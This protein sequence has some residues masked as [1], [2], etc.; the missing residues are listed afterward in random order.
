MYYLT[1]GTLKYKIIRGVF[2]TLIFGSAVRFEANKSQP[3]AMTMCTADVVPAV[4]QRS[5]E[6]PPCVRKLQSD[7]F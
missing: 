1:L 4:Q 5:E 2:F 3:M 7:I 6:V